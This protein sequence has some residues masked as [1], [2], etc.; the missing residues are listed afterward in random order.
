MQNKKIAKKIVKILILL[1]SLIL[2]VKFISFTLSR[3]ESKAK[4]SP[5]I[6][7]AMYVINKDFKTMN[8]NL[9]SLFP[10]DTPYVYTFSISNT[11]GNKRCETDMEYNLLLRATTNLPIEY[12]L[13]MNEDYTQAGAKDILTSNE[14]VKDEN[15]TYFRKMSTETQYF[16]YTEDQTNVYQLVVLFPQK[17]NTINYQDVIE[18]I[19]ITIDSKQVI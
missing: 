14:V 1:L 19:E 4:A 13:Y 15:D 12:K 10:S 18:G 5:N 8:I 11:D 16:G 17:Y 7:A 9:D 6:Q 3:Y 2:L